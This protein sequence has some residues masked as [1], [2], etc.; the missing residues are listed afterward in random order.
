MQVDD[1]DDVDAVGNIIIAFSVLLRHS[2]NQ[3]WEKA[4][5][6]VKKGLLRFH[7][8]FD[9]LSVASGR[10]F[11]FSGADI[12]EIDRGTF[13]SELIIGDFFFQG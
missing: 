11:V 12:R 4:A 1:D 2:T 9:E 7:R 5:A 10:M 8:A 13:F 6:F 3:R